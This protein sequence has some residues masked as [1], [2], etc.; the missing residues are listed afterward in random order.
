MYVLMAALLDIE[1]IIKML[2]VTVAS[3][4][5]AHT[6]L[7]E[8]LLLFPFATKL[9]SQSKNPKPETLN[10]NPQT[11]NPSHL[12]TCLFACRGKLRDGHTVAPIRRAGPDTS[13]S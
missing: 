9:L 1:C 7:H 13:D 4:V 2:L 5:L 3:V 12:S 10:P 8:R 11:L 6:E